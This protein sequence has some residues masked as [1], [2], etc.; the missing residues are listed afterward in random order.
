M[1]VMD[2]EI[3]HARPARS[4]DTKAA[5][6]YLKSSGCGAISITSDVDGAAISA[7][8]KP[9]PDA[10]AVYWLPEAEARSVAAKARHIAGDNPDVDEAISALMT[11]AAK[12]QVTLTAH[13]V[14]MARAGEM[15][16]RLDGYIGSL[17]ARGAMREFT[18]AYRRQRLAAGLRGEGFMSF[19]VAEA[20]LRLAL[21]PLLVG[22][23]NIQVQSLFET[24]FDR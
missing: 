8:A 11:A 23:N 15:A 21:I 24:I 7:G 18:K 10:V 13:D 5:L 20:R 19:K 12:C 4:P 22:G 16:R 6:V 3:G 14:A 17:R 9:D 2:V 1:T